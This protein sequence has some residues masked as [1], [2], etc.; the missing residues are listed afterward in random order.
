MTSSTK[1]YARCNI[2]WVAHRNK[3]IAYYANCVLIFLMLGSTRATAA[4]IKAPCEVIVTYNL[5]HLPQGIVRP[6]GIEVKHPDEFLID[7]YHVD[8]EIDVHELHQQGAE[9]K[10]PRTIS[11]V[12]RSL[13]ICKC[14]QFAQLIRQRLAL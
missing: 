4:A 1:P 5:K 8:N 9:L 14:T 3:R 13:E 12:L 7:L 2:S 6:Y 10:M 11:Q